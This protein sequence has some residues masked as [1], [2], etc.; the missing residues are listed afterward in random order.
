MFNGVK[1]FQ[2]TPPSPFFN[3]ARAGLRNCPGSFLRGIY[4]SFYKFFFVIFNEEALTFFYYG[5]TF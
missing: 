3:P 2:V 5:M 1:M 4:I